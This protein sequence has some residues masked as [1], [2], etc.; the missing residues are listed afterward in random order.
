MCKYEAQSN[1]YRHWYSPTA[2]LAWVDYQIVWTTRK[3]TKFV[4]LNRLMTK[5]LGLIVTLVWRYH[6]KPVLHV[7]NL[8]F[9]ILCL[10][11]AF[12][13]LYF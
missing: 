6:L 3:F 7:L 2:K 12:N 8:H 13:Y 4:T 10:M 11:A 5:I 9:A 1:L